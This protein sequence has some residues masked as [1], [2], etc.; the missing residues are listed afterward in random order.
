MRIMICGCV[1]FYK[2]YD[3]AVKVFNIFFMCKYLG[4]CKAWVMYAVC[5]IESQTELIAFY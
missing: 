3:E 1:S 2:K 5:I 4:L